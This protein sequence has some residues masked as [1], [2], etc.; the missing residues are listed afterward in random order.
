MTGQRFKVEIYRDRTRIDDLNNEGLIFDLAGIRYEPKLPGLRE[1]SDRPCAFLDSIRK[2]GSSLFAEGVFLS[3]HDGKQ[4]SALVAEGVPLKAVPAIWP[5]EI[6]DTDDGETIA[7]KS[8]LRSVH[9]CIVYG[10][11]GASVNFQALPSKGALIMSENRKEHPFLK[12]VE[13]IQAEKNCTK[14]QAMRLAVRQ[15]PEAHQRYIE[16]CNG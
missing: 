6:E 13:R 9:L 16:A 4:L 10:D 14:E 7:T 2:A 3:N 12:L 8:H 11:A 15:N 1:F 5:E